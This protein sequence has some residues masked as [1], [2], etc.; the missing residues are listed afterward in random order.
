M[1]EVDKRPMA[2]LYG[3][4]ELGRPM[5]DL[6]AATTMIRSLKQLLEPRSDLAPRVIVLGMLQVGGVSLG[7]VVTRIRRRWPMVDVV[8]WSSRATGAQVRTALNAG[9]KDVVMSTSVVSCARQVMEIVRSQQLL[10]KVARLG[11]ESRRAHEFEGMYARS[12]VMW[13]MF[14]TATRVASTDATVLILG[15]TGTGKELLAR[16]IHRCSGRTERFVPINCGGVTESLIESELFGHVRGA[17]TGAEHEKVGLFKHADGGTLFLD[18]IGNIPLAVQ[19]HLL[20]ALQEGAVRP[21]GGHDE[22]SVDARVIAATSSPLDVQVA[23]GQF[24]EDLFY[25]LDVIRL[26]IPPLRSRSDDIVFLF[27]KFAKRIA[28]SYNVERPDLA[29]DFIDALCSYEWPGNVRQLENLTER[30]VL[31]C[32]G[33]RVGADTLTKMTSGRAPASEARR[34]D[35]APPQVEVTRAETPAPEIDV[36]LPMEAAL[37]PK[38]DA[39]ERSYLDA[40]LRACNGRIGETAERAGIS[41]RTLLRKLSKH[42]L[43]KHS[44]R[45]RD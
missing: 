42:D 3:C 34:G 16:A 20:R 35:A 10:P 22:V 32:T 18:E 2:L 38:F 24:R 33:H 13:D 36:E 15:E 21:V 5:R 17:F 28:E 30:L 39:L 4:T 31:T 12:Q 40:C 26:E 8:V 23:A 11:L 41:R 19:Y 25:R 27:G 29:D 9:A 45:N 43:D 14:D 6:G 44:Y 7:E 37:A 1:Q